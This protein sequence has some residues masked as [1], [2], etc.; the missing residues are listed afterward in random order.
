MIYE[1]NRQIIA[2]FLFFDEKFNL[3]TNPA[4]KIH[5]IHNGCVISR[6]SFTLAS[7][8][9]P[10]QRFPSALRETGISVT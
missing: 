7:F 6:N 1:I 2:Y 4:P 3:K 8:Y 9:Q 10:F 5:L